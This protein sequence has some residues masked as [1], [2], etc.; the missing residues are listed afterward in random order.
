[1]NSINETIHERTLSFMISSDSLLIYCQTLSGRTIIN[2]IVIERQLVTCLI[3][4]IHGNGK[5]IYNNWVEATFHNSLK[6]LSTS[7]KAPSDVTR[8]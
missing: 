6:I 2:S 4:K 5:I 8:S 1:M 7:V 3:E